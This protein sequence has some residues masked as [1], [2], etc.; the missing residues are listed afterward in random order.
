MRRGRSLGPCEISQH[1]TQ[2]RSA[3]VEP[4]TG[5]R[6]AN[7]ADRD[8]HRDRQGDNYRGEGPGQHDASPWC[9]SWV[10]P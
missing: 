1:L 5:S 7:P 6:I 2:P 4:A 8:R 10:P 9:W 3:L